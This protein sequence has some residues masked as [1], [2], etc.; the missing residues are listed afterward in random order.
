MWAR[1]DICVLTGVQ[2]DDRNRKGSCSNVSCSC[3][4]LKKC[5]SMCF[6]QGGSQMEDKGMRLTDKG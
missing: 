3:K 4:N 2:S 1:P 5:V 6:T